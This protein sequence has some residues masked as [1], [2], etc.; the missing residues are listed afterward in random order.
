MALNCARNT[1][2]QDFKKEKITMKLPLDLQFFAE[3]EDKKSD[4]ENEKTETTEQN[5]ESKRNDNEKLYTQDELEQAI[6]SRMDRETKKRE[7]E[8]AE[9]EKLAKMNEAEKQKYE[10]E[11]LQE[12]NERLKAEQ[13]RWTLGKEATAMLSEHQ[14]QATD[15]ILNFVVGKDAEETSER[16]KAFAKLVEDTS[17]ALVQDKLK[18]NAPVRQK[19]SQPLTRDDIMK[20]KDP[21]ERI[22]LIQE[23]SHLFK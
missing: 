19:S 14:I 16:V 1:V 20:V 3:V 9:A 10:F 13:N 22:K 11:K 6:K 23:N 17:N 15:D 7:K 21:S 4:V 2:K 8:I 5:E 18:G 12:E